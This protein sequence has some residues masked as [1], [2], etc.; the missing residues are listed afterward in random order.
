MDGTSVADGLEQPLTPPCVLCARRGSRPRAPHHLAH[1]VTVWLCAAHGSDGFL[2]RRGG[3]DFADRLAAAWEAAGAMGARRAGAL[4]THLHQQQRPMRPRVKPGSYSWPR[5]R[6]EAERRFAAG[7]PPQRVI[8]ELRRR[9]ARAVAVVPSQRTMRRWFTEA[10]W[11][12]STVPFP[13]M[14]NRPRDRTVRPPRKLRP[15]PPGFNTR[16]FYPYDE[17]WERWRSRR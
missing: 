2:R 5:L 1:G 17:L 15:L 4:R 6:A 11:L 13:D 8:D 3:R 9:H 14:R 12:I 7:E 10:R 16:P